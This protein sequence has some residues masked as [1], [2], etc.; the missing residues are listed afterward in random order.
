MKLSAV[1]AATMTFT[2]P[3]HA[4]DGYL[5]RRNAYANA[6]ADAELDY[7]YAR[8]ADAFPD[9]S[10]LYARAAEAALDQFH[11][12]RDIHDDGYFER[13]DIIERGLGKWVACVSCTTWS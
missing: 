10:H 5:T 4:Y 11:E 3:I 7:L 13:R 12:V 9:P 1:I 6:D 2:L 8:D